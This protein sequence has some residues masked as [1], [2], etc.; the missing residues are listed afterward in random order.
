MLEEWLNDYGEVTTFSFNIYTYY[1]VRDNAI[2]NAGLTNRLINSSMADVRY[3]Q[4][5]IDIEEKDAELWNIKE[6]LS[7]QWVFPKKIHPSC[8]K[9]IIGII[10][11][12]LDF[13]NMEYDLLGVFGD[14]N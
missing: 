12:G 1:G 10:K 3:Y 13:L 2:I 14:V 5:V 9:M 8:K 4:S 7:V 6:G 11:E